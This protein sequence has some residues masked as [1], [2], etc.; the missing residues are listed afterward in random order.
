M[1]GVFVS[2]SQSRVIENSVK[3]FSVFYLF[4]SLLVPHHKEAGR[5]CRMALKGDKPEDISG[6]TNQPCLQFQAQH[7][8]THGNE[9]CSGMPGCQDMPY[10]RTSD[11]HPGAHPHPQQLAASLQSF[12][13]RIHILFPVFGLAFRNFLPCPGP[14]LPPEQTLLSAIHKAIS[15]PNAALLTGREGQAAMHQPPDVLLLSLPFPFRSNRAQ[16]LKQSP[17]IPAPTILLLLRKAVVEAE[18]EHR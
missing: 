14:P 17:L 12:P 13:C 15:S 10:T 5:W 2:R 1:P 18:M 6:H 7:W 11:H 3:H 16:E 9:G 8:T 4:P